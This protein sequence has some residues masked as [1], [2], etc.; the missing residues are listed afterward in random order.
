M[1]VLLL[2]ITLAFAAN[3][4]SLREGKELD[5]WKMVA[6]GYEVNV[7]TYFAPDTIR[8]NGNEIKLWAM[9]H[10]PE[11]VPEGLLK[12]A[13]LQDVGTFRIYLVLSCAEKR[14]RG[15]AAIVYDR[16][17]RIIAAQKGNADVSEKPES[18]GN[19]IF[20]YFCERE[21]PPPTKPPMLKPQPH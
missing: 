8:R 14:L 18:I 16:K 20:N 17:D 21:P 3:A 5:N 12:D 15:T 7:K 13:P 1:K 4:Q 11:G 9:W 2:I 19:A 6:R 10:F